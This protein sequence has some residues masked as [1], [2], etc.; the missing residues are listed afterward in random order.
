MTSNKFI[1]VVAVLFVLSVITLLLFVI[2]ISATSSPN[3]VIPNPDEKSETTIVNEQQTFKNGELFSSNPWKTN[4]KI[5]N[6]IITKKDGKTT[7]TVRDGF[8]MSGTS[9]IVNNFNGVNEN[10][11]DSRYYF[12]EIE[13]GGKL[14]FDEKGTL[15][16]AKFTVKGEYKPNIG[17]ERQGSKELNDLGIKN[18]IF[19]AA[20]AGSSDS[21]SLAG[22][23]QN[24]ENPFVG[25][26]SSIEFGAG[27]ESLTPNYISFQLSNV[28]INV[29]RGS[30]VDFKGSSLTIKPTEG[31][32]VYLPFI[33]NINH[34]NS[35][36]DSLSNF[37]INFVP[38]NYFEIANSGITFSGT[39]LLYESKNLRSAGQELSFNEKAVI[40][41]VDINPDKNL[42]LRFDI[43]SSKNPIAGDTMFLLNSA[44]GK[45]AEGKPIFIPFSQMSFDLNPSSELNLKFNPGNPIFEMPKTSNYNLAVD[46]KPILTTQTTD[47][48]VPNTRTLTFIGGAYSYD[49][50]SGSPSISFDP[51]SEITIKNGD[52]S[53]SAKLKSQGGVDIYHNPNSEV[54]ASSTK[55]YEPYPIKTISAAEKTIVYDNNNE[56]ISVGTRYHYLENNQNLRLI[57]TNGETVPNLN[58]FSTPIIINSNIED[59]GSDI[60]E[61]EGVPPV[62]CAKCKPRGPTIAP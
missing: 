32:K 35:K 13:Q 43:P 62:G 40:N 60:I 29:A 24:K 30:D 47:K 53:Y 39:N 42:F 54:S 1:S 38:K 46:F 22:G 10:F 27:G 14:V 57:A 59:K 45:D 2:F 51:R 28:N 37:N 23:Q 18:E 9:I 61:I 8:E 26:R 52:D 33:Y 20:Q 48:S 41:G 16:E 11:E 6:A 7:I 49:P 31:S 3:I 36:A 55:S 34:D 17:Q 25:P 58:K 50:L 56:V 4:V 19:N 12:K 5:E 21:S 44:T 15:I